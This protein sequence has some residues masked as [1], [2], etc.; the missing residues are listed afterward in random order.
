MATI[1]RHEVGNCIQVQDGRRHVEAWTTDLS[2]I[3][4]FF[5]EQQKADHRPSL[6]ELLEQALRAGVSVLRSSGME[7][8]IDYV[9]RQFARRPNRLP[10]A[11]PLSW[12]RH[13]WV[14]SLLRD[15][16]PIILT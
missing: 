13:E 8:R 15:E 14:L 5:D 16:M 7:A 2:F 3:V 4:S 10:P 11:F 9:E 1:V 12:V 6:L